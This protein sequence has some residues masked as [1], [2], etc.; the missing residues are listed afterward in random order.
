[1][2]QNLNLSN[3]NQF[4]QPLNV[5]NPVTTEDEETYSSQLETLKNMGFYNNTHNINALKYTNGNIE[6]AVNIILNNS[7]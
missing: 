7:L 4:Q 5:N 1:M 3:Q 6:E 2:F